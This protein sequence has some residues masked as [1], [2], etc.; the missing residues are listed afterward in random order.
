MARSRSSWPPLPKLTLYWRR[1]LM[2]FKE[3]RKKI[4]PRIAA[5]TAVTG[6]W[7]MSFS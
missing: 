1:Y 6:K 7:G 4:N 2:A 3:R 5:V